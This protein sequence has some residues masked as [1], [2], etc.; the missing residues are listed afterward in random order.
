MKKAV[1][2]LI[3]LLCLTGCSANNTAQPGEETSSGTA[4]SAE[5]SS[6]GLSDAETDKGDEILAMW[7][8]DITLQDPFVP[9]QDLSTFSYKELSAPASEAVPIII[10]L[11]SEELRSEKIA[12]SEGG[13]SSKFAISEMEEADKDIYPKVW[14]LLR[15]FNEFSEQNA[16]LEL[17]D[18]ETRHSAYAQMQNK[19][20]YLFLSSWTGIELCRADSGLVS[21][22]RTVYRYNREIEP[23]YHEIYGTTIDSVTG[24]V[25]TL[26]D[27]FTDTNELPQMIWDALLRSGWRN[28]DDPDKDAFI[29]ILTTAVQ[30]CR[31]DGS[32]GWTIDPLGIEFGLIETRTE[33]DVVRHVRERAYIPFS[34]CGGILRPGIADL[35]CDYMI[36]MSREDVEAVTGSGIPAEGSGDK[37][38]DHY[39][40]QRAGGK[41]LYSISDNLTD[42]YRI[43]DAGFE[44]TGEIP[45]EISYDHYD[46]MRSVLSPESYKLY[47]TADL[48]QE[49]FLE[50]RAYTDENGMVVRN[51]YYEPTTNPM[52][53]FTGAVFEADIFPD[54]DS[55]E[56]APGTV[57]K[58]SVLTILRT[59]GETFVDCSI[60]N[61]DPIA[62]LY[63][64]SNENGGW[65]VNGHP[66]DE[67]IEYQGWLEE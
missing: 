51:G 21:I 14:A 67:V 30:G 12:S 45:A 54:S 36:Q 26:N 3:I 5:V 40:V 57:P 29:E 34:I 10:S 19:K 47:R 55:T 56:S 35:S 31:D 42:I 46:H 53:I 2:L 13:A 33:G 11:K 37:Y 41:Y 44:K 49:L 25:L 23:D 48:L 58:H 62:R 59:D 17:S 38:F 16:I 6:S 22:F 28:E 24:R 64:E 50:A 43:T 32:F 39:I 61:E 18:A 27:I 1:I 52:P 15:N 63:L 7:K 8:K 60:D 4:V 20:S 66:M 9:T 65:T